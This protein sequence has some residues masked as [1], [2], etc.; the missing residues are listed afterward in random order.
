MVC[1]LKKK[2]RYNRT[3]TIS[4]TYNTQF[5]E[6]TFEKFFTK[7][8]QNCIDLLSS[9]DSKFFY[10]NLIHNIDVNLKRSIFQFPKFNIFIKNFVY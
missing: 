5:G 10:R 9:V 6:L 7:F 8:G 1:S 2:L 3:I 4:E